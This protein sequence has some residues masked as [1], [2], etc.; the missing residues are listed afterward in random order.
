MEGVMGKG[1]LHTAKGV[2]LVERAMAFQAAGLS[3]SAAFAQAVGE[4]RAREAAGFDFDRWYEKDR[5]A[6]RFG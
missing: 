3:E 5:P 4:V 2:W 1:H 6:G